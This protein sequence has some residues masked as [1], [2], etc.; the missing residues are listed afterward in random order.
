MADKQSKVT[1]H[2]VSSLDG[3]IAKA[4]G[5][6]SWLHSTDNYENGVTLTDDY[7]TE[8]VDSIDCYVMGSKTY[9]HALELGWAYGDKPVYVLTSRNL[10]TV[11]E[12]VEFCSGDLAGL[13]KNRVRK[14]TKI[15]GSPEARC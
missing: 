1:I 4:D 9:E 8:F 15:Y 5:D 7:I 13:I 14:N 2:M 6:V 11:R 10:N 3:F 12:N